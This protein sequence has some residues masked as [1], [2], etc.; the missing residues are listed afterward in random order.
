LKVETNGS[1]PCRKRH[2][3]LWRAGAVV[4][5]AAASGVVAACSSFDATPK[6]VL[7]R[8][9][10]TTRSKELLYVLVGGLK[11]GLPSIAA[12]DARDGSPNPKPLYTIRPSRGETYDLL[13]VD[14]HG[15]LF[16]SQDYGSPATVTMFAPG[17]SKPEATCRLPGIMAMYVAEGKLFVSTP[18]YVNMIAEYAEPF[19]TDGCGRPSKT[20]TDQLANEQ[21]SS[22]IFGITV[23]NQGNVFDTWRGSTGSGSVHMDVFKAKSKDAKLFANLKDSDSTTFLVVDRSNDIVTNLSGNGS[24]N[25]F[26][27][28]FRGE[29]N[30]P[31]LSHPLGLA[32]WQGVAFGSGQAELFALRTN[33]ALSVDVFAYD[34]KAGVISKRKRG[35]G[36]IYPGG[37]SIAVYAR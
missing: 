9:S 23:D 4:L 17:S 1:N 20:L 33:P 25:D 8:A 35:F 12:F 16:A 5:L 7:Q 14:H 30:K 32:D 11:K 2:S 36:S 34:P 28:V 19:P 21:R 3:P 22:G 31:T 26:L 37:R 18:G 13:A 15:N 29:S 10:K 24:L 6:P 27:A